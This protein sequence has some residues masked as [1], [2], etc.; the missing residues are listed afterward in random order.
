M[1]RIPLL[2]PLLLATLSM[3]CYAQLS[4]PV[5]NNA[6]PFGSGAG[7]HSPNSPFPALEERSDVLPW[8]V[9]TPLK[10]RSRRKRYCLYFRFPLLRWTKRANEFRGS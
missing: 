4:S 1:K 7:V 9:L 5:G 10:P 6:V 3:A 2:V 8:S